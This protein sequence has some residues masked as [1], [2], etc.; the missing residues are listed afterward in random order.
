[1]AEIFTKRNI[2][3][4]DTSRVDPAALR[5]LGEPNRRRIV[6]LLDGAPRSVGEIA[7][8]LG[9]RQPQT[10]KHLQ[11]LE[12]V[13]L[14]T[15]H[16]LGQRRIYALRREPFRE[17]SQWLDSLA[18]E[19]P[20]ERVLER[21]SDAIEAERLLALKDPN[22]AIT[23]R[24]HFT[25]PLAAPAS[26]V[27]SYWT[28]AELVRRWWSPEHFE[29]IECQVEPVAGGHLEIVMQEG[30]GTRHLARG[31][32]LELI[33]PKHVRF[34]L[35][36]IGPDGSPLLTAVHDLTLHDRGT[37]TELSLDITITAASSAAAPALAGMQFGWEQL[38]DKLARIIGVSS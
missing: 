35:G 7:A 30:D 14:V 22:W 25:R 15:M 28:S 9:L 13:G 24:L 20:S 12:R 4:V 6:E 27:W 36:P 8:E 5:A 3:A 21:Y 11:T 1:L 23:R 31:Q 29:V 10:T 32:F 37:R 16:P 34:E 18:A 26:I 2:Y 19:H 17:L 38:L 33:P